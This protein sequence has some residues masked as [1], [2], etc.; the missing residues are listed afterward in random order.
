MLIISF[1]CCQIRLYVVYSVPDDL[2]CC[3]PEVMICLSWVFSHVKNTHLI[4]V[5]SFSCFISAIKWSRMV[6]CDHRF[7]VCHGKS[8]KHWRI[9]L[10]LCGMLYA[11]C[12]RIWYRKTF[13]KYEVL[14]W[15]SVSI[16]VISGFKIYFKFRWYP[17]LIY[18]NILFWKYWGSF[19]NCLWISNW[20]AGH[21][22]MRVCIS[23]A[24]LQRLLWCYFHYD[25]S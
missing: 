22:L 10:Q 24:L 21:L 6:S 13:L 3:L 23:F 20:T 16:S 8:A 25:F 1:Y 5:V 11:G 7:R 15:I 2:K 4:C 14:F 12:Y 9:I 17:A 18:L 19:W